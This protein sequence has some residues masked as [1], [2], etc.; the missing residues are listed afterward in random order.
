M[1]ATA[2]V[3]QV[4][5]KATLI[6]HINELLPGCS[7]RFLVSILNQAEGQDPRSLSN[8][9]R[10]AL[11]CEVT[12]AFTSDVRMGVLLGDCPIPLPARFGDFDH[13]TQKVVLIGVTPNAARRLG[14]RSLAL[15]ESG[16]EGLRTYGYLT[17]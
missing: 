4:G 2:T 3:P 13:L 6:Q 17:E 5:L 12:D 1:T 8:T 16:E 11:Q 7:D 15:T 10:N 9:V 14:M